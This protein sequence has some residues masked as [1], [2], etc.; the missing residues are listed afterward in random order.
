MAAGKIGLAI[1]VI[2]LI[3]FVVGQQVGLMPGGRIRKHVTGLRE[4]SN[5]DSFEAKGL[6]V[7]GE[8][9]VPNGSKAVFIVRSHGGEFLVE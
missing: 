4:V 1:S 3:G 8:A 7:H 2:L 9:E 6:M 5:C